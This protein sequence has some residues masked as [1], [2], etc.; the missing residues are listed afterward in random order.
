MQ[1]R[2]RKRH[3]LFAEQAMRIFDRH[4]RIIDEDADRQGKPP[5]RH[6]IEGLA[7]KVEHDE[8]RQDRKR[9]RDHD[10]EGG[11]P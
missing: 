8:G 7:E 1:R 4:G 9:N 5:E 2:L 3:F 6:G 11:A 10:D